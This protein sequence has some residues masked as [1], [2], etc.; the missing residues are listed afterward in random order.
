[1]PAKKSR[2]RRPRRYGPKAAQP[3]RPLSW[4]AVA[5]G[6]IFCSPACGAGCTKRAFK[7]ATQQAFALAQHC[8]PGW[9]PRVWEN[10]GWFCEAVSPCGRYR[11][12]PLSGSDEVHVY[13]GR[14]TA[15]GRTPELALRRVKSKIRAEIRALNYLLVGWVK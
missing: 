10:M 5:R 11:V 4:R 8:G 9:T 1:M 3:R 12:I 2:S 7:Q 13:V 15:M 14:F 6:R